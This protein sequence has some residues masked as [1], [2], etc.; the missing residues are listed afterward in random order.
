AVPASRLKSL[1]FILA[2][3]YNLIPEC[4]NRLMVILSLSHKQETI[5]MSSCSL[6]IAGSSLFCLRGGNTFSIGL[7]GSWL[8]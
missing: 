7:A 6:L 5:F 4:H 1:A 2:A 8:V 3:S